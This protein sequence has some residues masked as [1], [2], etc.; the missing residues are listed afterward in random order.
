M[1]AGSNGL[2]ARLIPPKHILDKLKKD[3][4]LNALVQKLEKRLDASNNET[5]NRS[6]KID[7]ATAHLCDLSSKIINFEENIKRDH[8][9]AD[10][11][12]GK[13]SE[14]IN[15]LNTINNALKII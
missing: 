1:I 2:K 3:V 6:I 14:I 8:P 5:V 11:L 4:F 15:S 10:K 9:D 13:L 7:R 12:L